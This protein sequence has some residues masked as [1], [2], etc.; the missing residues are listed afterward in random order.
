MIRNYQ[1]SD[2][3]EIKALHKEQG[4]DYSLYDL[5]SPLCFVKKVRVEGGRVVAAL[6]LRLTAET[7]LICS[8]SSVANGRAIEELQPEVL[9]EAYRKGLD[10][11][12]CVIP[13]EILDSFQPALDRM[14]WTRDRDGWVMFSRSTT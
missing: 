8:G 9:S 3:P 14:K 2:L 13:P 7:C 4:L 11:V 12:V 6:I 10:E 1:P 5:D